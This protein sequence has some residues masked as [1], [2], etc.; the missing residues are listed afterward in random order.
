[1]KKKILIWALLLMTVASSSF[2]IKGDDLNIKVATSFK[3]DFAGAREIRWETGKTFV[4]VTFILNDQIM[5]AYYTENGDFMAVSRN[6]LSNNLPLALQIN[7]KRDYTNYW[8]TELFEIDSDNEISY[9]ITL[10]NSGFKLTLKSNSAE[11]WEAYKKE[12]K[13]D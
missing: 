9:Y 8:I 5:F 7:L 11:G 1:M 4:K 2:A 6:I 12:T 10:E 13:I 3:K